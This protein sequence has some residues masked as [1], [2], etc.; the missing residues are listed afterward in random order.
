MSNNRKLLVDKYYL[1][2][3][4]EDFGKS[5]FEKL[6]KLF[7][8]EGSV[9]ASLK[10]FKE[11]FIK[12]AE[13]FLDGN[14]SVNDFSFLAGDVFYVFKKPNYFEERDE[15]FAAA[16]HIISDMD[17]SLDEESIQDYRERGGEAENAEKVK[18]WFKVVRGYIEDL[19]S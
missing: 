11:M 4:K 8:N 13:D 3:L 18:H 1:K 12:A 9:D 10:Q 16:L 19:S 17:F 15:K 5:P 2:F 7:R 6:D 14:L